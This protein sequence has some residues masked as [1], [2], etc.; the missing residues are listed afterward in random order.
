MFRSILGAFAKQ[1]PPTVDG[2]GDAGWIIYERQLPFVEAAIN[3][4][5]AQRG[6]DGFAA[7]CQRLLDWSKGAHGPAARTKGVLDHMRKELLEI[8]AQPDDLEEWIDMVLLSINGAMR[9]GFTPAQIVGGLLAK[10]SKNEDRV[11]P[12]WRTAD[13]DK[14][15]EHV[16]TEV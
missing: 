3:K 5:L 7:F 16:R 1:L 14:A 11:W 10:M 4:A 15:I 8:E 12:D 9:R 2:D 6:W 13:P